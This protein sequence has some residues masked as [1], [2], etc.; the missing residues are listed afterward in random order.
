VGADRRYG[1]V[2]AAAA[3]WLPFE[4]S[5]RS[6]PVPRAAQGTLTVAFL[7]GD[8]GPAG[9]GEAL[10]WRGRRPVELLIESPE[11]LERAVLAFGRRAPN[12]LEVLAGGAVADRLLRADGGV[13]FA[14]DLDRA[15][16]VHPVRAGGAPVHFYVLRLRL[17]AAPPFD[18][19]FTVKSGGW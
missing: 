13:S 10:R 3:R 5:Q 16:A 8:A 15:R 14:I 18:L 19:P 17:P 7:A 6:L 9:G 12:E 1:Y 11:P 2:S 4:T